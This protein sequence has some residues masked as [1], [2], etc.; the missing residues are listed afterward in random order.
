MN[1]VKLM[2]T[3]RDSKYAYPDLNPLYFLL[4]LTTLT[5][6]KTLGLLIFFNKPGCFESAFK[7]H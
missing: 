4:H 1:Q 2:S 5:Y 6:L 7:Y 3:G